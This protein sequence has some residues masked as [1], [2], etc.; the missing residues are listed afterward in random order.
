MLDMKIFDDV[1]NEDMDNFFFDE[2]AAIMNTLNHGWVSSD[3]NVAHVP[4]KAEIIKHVRKMLID[5]YDRLVSNDCKY[6]TTSTGGYRVACHHDDDGYW[7]DIMYA[8]VETVR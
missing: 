2:A 7:A 3:D 8:P 4:G 6:M 5:T 1:I